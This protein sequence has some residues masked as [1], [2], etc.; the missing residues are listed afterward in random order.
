MKKIKVDC[1]SHTSVSFDGNISPAA[2]VKQATG[3]GIGA[4]IISD[5]NSIEGALAVRALNPPFRVIVSEEIQSA[6]GEIIGAFL[7]EKIPNKKPAGWTFDAIHEQG[8]LAIV[9]HPFV[10]VVVSRLSLSALFSC[11]DKIDI[12]EVVNARNN[13]LA[14]EVA[15]WRFAKAHNLPVC[16]GSDAH[17]SHALGRAYVLMDPFE[18][19]QEFLKNI[20]DGTTVCERRTPL[21]LS[22]VTFVVPLGLAVGKNISRFTYSSLKKNASLLKNR[23][24]KASADD[25]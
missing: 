21:W 6:E 7:E 16:A 9:P 10:K 5:H 23:N 19:P 8:G 14:D 12:V 1:H 2:Y 13:S 24:K 15:A 4:A 22:G 3:L 18:T 25:D 20:K 11:L 17:L